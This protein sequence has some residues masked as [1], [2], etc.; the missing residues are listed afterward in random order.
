MHSAMHIL[1]FPTFKVRNALVTAPFR[2]PGVLLG[3]HMLGFHLQSLDLA[4]A[5]ISHAI[6]GRFNSCLR[7]EK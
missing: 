3:E 2:Q 1:P 7:N 6:E 5:E 4:E